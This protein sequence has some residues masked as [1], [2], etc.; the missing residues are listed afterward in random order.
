MV[1]GMSLSTNLEEEEEEDK[2]SSEQQQQQQQHAK[3]FGGTGG[4]TPDSPYVIKRTPSGALLD[5]LGNFT[6]GG[7]MMGA[8]A[9]GGGDAL[10]A[11]PPPR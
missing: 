2:A 8:G 3:R 4:Q 7:M 9:S 10:P 1:G 5:A 11:L 6:L